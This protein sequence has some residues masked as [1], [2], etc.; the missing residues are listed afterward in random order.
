M[1]PYQPLSRSIAGK[2]AIVTG[3]ASGMGRATAHLFASEGA[4]VAVTDLDQGK[5]DAVVQEIGAAGYKGSAKAWALDVSDQAAIKAVVG[6]IAQAFGGIDIL[7]NNAGFA[8]PADVAEESY[9]DSWDPTLAVMLAAHQ[10]MIRAALPHLRNAEH[11]RIVNVASTEGMGATPGNS[12]Y[13]AAKHGVIGLTRGLAV[14]LGREGITVNC[15]CPGPIRTGITDAISEEHKTIYAKR[16]VPLRRYGI[17]EEVAH[18]TL[19]CVLPSASF[20][21]GAVIP[22][23][24]GLTIKNA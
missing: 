2:V 9:E 24:G 16:R 23:D 6:D 17:P 5:C 15:I 11:P 3:A 21:T 7:V 8:I 18:L 4:H 14:D 22:V 12:P 10:R 13:V 19:S 20:L 1:E